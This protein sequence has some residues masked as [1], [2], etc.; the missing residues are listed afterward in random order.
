LEPL[1][2]SEAVL[3]KEEKEAGVA[4]VDIGGGT[5]DI[6]IFKDNIIRHTCVIPYGGGIITEDIKEGCSI[7]EKH[8]EQLKVK[9]GSAVPELEKDSTF[10]T[11]PGLHGR[12]DKEISLKT[13]AQIIN[14][15]V[16]EI[17]EMVNTELKAYGA[18][19]QKKKLI[20]GIVLTGGGSNLKHLRQLA[21]YTTGFDSRI[22]FANEY[23]AND[24]NQYLKGPEFATSIGLLMESLK[25]R[26]KKQTVEER[27]SCKR[28]T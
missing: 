4:I 1:A 14:A 25:I 22:G 28:A 10:V 17:L 12:P 13:L 9:F 18:F 21:N 5:T 16:E 11:I 6:A 26:D 3:T 20:A 19:E 2:S 8:A 27:R 23:I 24:K 7:I 15:R